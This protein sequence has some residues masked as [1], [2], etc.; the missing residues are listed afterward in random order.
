MEKYRQTLET[1]RNNQIWGGTIFSDKPVRRMGKKTRHDIQCCRMLVANV[2]RSES[3]SF[4]LRGFAELAQGG[5]QIIQI[6]FLNDQKTSW[7]TTKDSKRNCEKE[8]K[9]QNLTTP[10]RNGWLND[11][12]FNQ[13]VHQQFSLKRPSVPRNSH[14]A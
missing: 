11:G 13:I 12:S 7:T 9:S 5:S 1:I 8:P 3:S 10:T 14:R 4:S 6:L 2:D